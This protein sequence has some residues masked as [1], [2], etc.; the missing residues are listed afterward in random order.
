MIHKLLFRLI[1]K[2]IGD[3]PFDVEVDKNYME[4]WFLIPR[5]RV[6]NIYF[7][8]FIGSDAPIPHDHPWLC[9]SFI[10]DGEY[11]EHT[12][13]G[14]FKRSAGHVSLKPA[15]SLH[16]IEI[17]SPVYTIFFT[18]P[19]YRDWG[20]QCENKWVPHKQYIEQRGSNRLANGCGEP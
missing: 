11:I 5:N 20:F 18:G 16:W 13:N 10:L 15:K 19:R 8:R 3:R 9:L 6:F 4:R 2:I 7:H 14:S 12:P 1:K 17:E